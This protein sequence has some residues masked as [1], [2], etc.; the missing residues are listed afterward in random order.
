VI[1]GKKV[2]NLK[3][4]TKLNQRSLIV[5]V[6]IVTVL[7]LFASGC[8]RSDVSQGQARNKGTR[9]DVPQEI[10]LSFVHP[11][12][13]MAMLFQMDAITKN[14]RFADFSWQEIIDLP[15]QPADDPVFTVDQIKSMT[16]LFDGGKFRNFANKEIQSNNGDFPFDQ[17]IVLTGKDDHFATRVKNRID[18][19]QQYQRDSETQN[20]WVNNS[21]SYSVYSRN[22]HQVMIGKL[23]AVKKLISE[24]PATD[25]AKAI[26]RTPTN[27]SL[28]LVVDLSVF[29]ML[30][31]SLEQVLKRVAPSQ[32]AQFELL[33]K[34]ELISADV[35]FDNA[36]LIRSVI[37]M[38]DAE[39]AGRFAGLISEQMNQLLAGAGKSLGSN[40]PDDQ[41]PIKLKSSKIMQDVFTNLSPADY[42]IELD[43]S[44]INVELNRFKQTDELLAA[45]SSDV[46]LTADYARRIENLRLVAKGLNQYKDQHGNYPPAGRLEQN[47]DQQLPAQFNWRV[48]ILPHIGYEDLY[49]EFKFDESWDSSH[50]QSVAEKMPSL[51]LTGSHDGRTALHILNGSITGYRHSMPLPD[52]EVTD[53]ITNTLMVAEMS[54]EESVPWTSPEVPEIGPEYDTSKFGRRNERFVLAV[55]LDGK[56]KIVKRTVS[57]IGALLSANGGE[58]VTSEMTYPTGFN[59][60]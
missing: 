1:I 21:D 41:S 55:T 47:N 15:G 33:T 22:D 49:A 56:L 5:C 52:A 17:V 48:G 26:K 6:G 38:Q 37:T 51:L 30:L 23:T 28:K 32:A 29:D 31:A 7:T 58:K 46:K 36:K 13:F 40:V 19:L 10:E 45:I 14:G 12:H 11:D 42:S 43:G 27:A 25:L 53:G 57:A 39:S 9:S 24:S 54:S 18:Q 34:I 20:L 8:W 50:N 44:N 59:Q 4:D 16:I 3:R 2:M 60:R 35:D